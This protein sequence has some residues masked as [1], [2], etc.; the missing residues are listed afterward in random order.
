MESPITS[1]LIE[2][3]SP[4]TARHVDIFGEAT[5]WP[6]PCRWL[7]SAFLSGL[8]P[9]AAQWLF[10]LGGLSIIASLF[11]LSPYLRIFEHWKE[12]TY[13]LYPRE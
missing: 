11:L 5:S 3:L 4:P 13:A 10:I 6:D 1:P 2:R 12:M 7:V 8:W 9:S